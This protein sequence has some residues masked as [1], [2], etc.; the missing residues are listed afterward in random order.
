MPQDDFDYGEEFYR[1][2]KGA[3]DKL[4]GEV[5]QRINQTV[6]QSHTVAAGQRQFWDD[7]YSAN[8]DLDPKEDHE[9]VQLVLNSNMKALADLPVSEASQ[10]LSELVEQKI[11]YYRGD[12]RLTPDEED[13][14]L[15]R[16]GPEHG[17]VYREPRS[18]RSQ[19]LGDTIRDRK[20]ARYESNRS[21]RSGKAIAE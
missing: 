9:L 5:Q 10:K 18:S 14:R 11:A 13:R 7:F 16:G 15:M 20:M 8:Q 12:R 4:L 17:T 3:V 2:P 21:L 6:V 1:D 19:S